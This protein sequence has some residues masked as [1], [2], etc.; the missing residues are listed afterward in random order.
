MAYNLFKGSGLSVPVTPLSIFG[1]HIMW[2]VPA[3]IKVNVGHPLFVKD[4]WT[5]EEVSTVEAFRA[6]LERT[7]SGL[8][9]ES[10]SW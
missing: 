4:Y 6:A 3:T 1:T 7:V 10:L 2:A 5:G 9:R 8:F